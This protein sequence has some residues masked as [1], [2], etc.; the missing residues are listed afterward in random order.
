MRINSIRLQNFRQHADTYIEFDAGLTGILGANGT[1]K[2][3]ILEAIAWALYG[4]PAA[5]GKRE[6]IKSLRAPARAGV[7]VELDFDLGGHRYQVN[8][9]LTNA[10]VYLDRGPAPIANSISGVAEVLR[11][12]LG[13]SHSEFFN[14]YFT[15]Q[16][17]LSVMA[18]MGTTE[19]AQFLSRLLGYERLKVAQEIARERRR[20]IVAELNGVKSGMADEDQ[21]RSEASDAERGVK[22]ADD[23]AAQ[24]A[25][26]HDAARQA[27]AALAPG[28]ES[29]QAE[30]ATVQRIEGDRRVVESER[31]ARQRELDR[32]DREL[33]DLASAQ[34]EL[35]SLR[36]AIEPL[37]SVR[38]ELEAM[39]ALAREEGRR[40]ALLKQE[41][42]L[43][44]EYGKL[45]DRR[46]QLEKAPRAAKAHAAELK[47]A[48]TALESAEKAF[49]AARTEWVRDRQEAETRV[50]QLKVQ[51]ADVKK[52]RETLLKEGE[53]GTCPICARPLGDHYR[54]VLDEIEE[55]LT[56][57]KQNG[58]YFSDR[59]KQLASAPPDV[60]KHETAK[61]AA[62]KAVTMLE[63]RQM[64]IQNELQELA[65][66]DA[67][68]VDRDAKLVALK[69][70][71][72]RAPAGYSAELHAQ[73]RARGDELQ[74][75]ESQANR[76]SGA[77]ERE[78]QLR[79]DRERVATALGIVVS[80]IADLDR[81]RAAFPDVERRFEKTRVAH[82]GA[83]GTLRALDVEL[84][85]AQAKLSS[86]RSR[87]ESATRAVADLERAIARVDELNQERRLHEELDREYSDFRNELNVQ[88]RPEL[89]E[90][91]SVLL[92]E[93]TDGRYSELELDEN[94]EIVLI[95]NGLPKHV[96]SGG[97]E[98]LAN[99]VLR[100]SISQM[101]AERAG[102]PLSLLILDEVFGSL[103]ESRRA[104]VLDMLHHLR[105]Q[106]E[107]IIAISHVEAVSVYGVL[108][109]KIHLTYDEQTET[110]RVS[111]E[112][113]QPLPD[114]DQLDLGAA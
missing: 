31:V 58:R 18:A 68:L 101:I 10:E 30:V 56:S 15:G 60:V 45:E 9:T 12:R 79:L 23:H 96:I 77:L 102:Q 55:Q 38:A 98:D 107:Q 51:L 105:D 99:L 113:Q 69:G 2:S 35:T 16:K 88:L 103:D 39:D 95:E 97:E 76:L 73:L 104:N 53:N 83:V 109:K 50:E 41:R 94:Y 111:Y 21:V 112:S 74:T 108:D 87:L 49:D 8:R 59:M 19:R 78:S 5:R 86:A 47:E 90:Q 42:E 27:L 37:A 4:N 110:S 100:I 32:H 43:V 93:L 17:E 80:R 84:A 70:E 65:S 25:A 22:L 89:S 61:V 114:E 28:W 14:T 3:T 62:A 24:V 26:R 7:R 54:S 1:G 46:K 67:A 64:L 48:K 75:L 66:V 11:R 52:Q 82:E 29:V 36:A 57:I 106:F 85:T 44:V 13:M 91:A 34:A 40:Q 71:I 63:S 20:T 92:A 81:E 72:T 33:S 6:T